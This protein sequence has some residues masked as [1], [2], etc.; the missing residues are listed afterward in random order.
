MEKWQT[1]ENAL[2]A[3]LA[4]QRR[5]GT[6]NPRIGWRVS[7]TAGYQYFDHAN[8][9]FKVARELLNGAGLRRNAPEY[10]KPTVEKMCLSKDCEARVIE[11]WGTSTSGSFSV[12]SRVDRDWTGPLEG[13][14]KPR[15]VREPNYIRRKAIKAP[16]VQLVLNDY[17]KTL[18]Q[19]ADL[20]AVLITGAKDKTSAPIKST[21]VAQQLAFS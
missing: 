14:D 11:R 17:W 6:K 8:R 13:P 20:V 21:Q 2:A 10:M 1:A 18:K 4:E 7:I 12:Y 16:G 9:A 3:Y 15:N 19:E 5:M